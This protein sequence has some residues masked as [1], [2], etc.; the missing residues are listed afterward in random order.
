MKFG[1]FA[2]NWMALA[3][4]AGV[5]AAALIASPQPVLVALSRPALGGPRIGGEVWAGPAPGLS[6][7]GWSSSRGSGSRRP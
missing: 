3:R 2:L 6:E 1:Y 4:G 5:G 7:R